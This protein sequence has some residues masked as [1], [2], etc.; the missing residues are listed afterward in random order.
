VGRVAA[1]DNRI[2]CLSEV[3][4][5]RDLS[6]AE[7]NGIAAAMPTRTY[8]LG[9]LVYSPRHPVEG[10]FILKHGVWLFR[11]STFPR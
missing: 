2:W 9:E 3:D 6:A 4:I 7:M 10:L 1:V 8:A 5:F 11:V